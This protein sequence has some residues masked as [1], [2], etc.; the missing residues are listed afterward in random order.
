M[1]LALSSE[2]DGTI[3]FYREPKRN[4]GHL[5]ALFPTDP[6]T[7]GVRTALTNEGYVEFGPGYLRSLHPADQDHDHETAH[8]MLKNI[9]ARAEYVQSLMAPIR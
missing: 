1:A 6:T 5:L 7:P 2:Y 8:Q 3:R 4:G 9:N